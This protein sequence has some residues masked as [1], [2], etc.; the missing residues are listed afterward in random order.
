MM[1]NR[2]RFLI[3]TGGAVLG[4]PL[5][6][7]P[8][9]VRADD[10]V[11][12]L[13]TVFFGNGLPP[14]YAADLE[15]PLSP[16]APWR[17]QLSVVRGLDGGFA[18]EDNRLDPHLQGSGGF[19]V[20]HAPWGPNQAGGISIDRAAYVAQHPSTPLPTLEMGMYNRGAERLRAVKTWASPRRPYPPIQNPA[21]LF[22]R[23]FGGADPSRSVLDAVVGEYRRVSSDAAGYSIASRALIA[24][25]LD[26][27][28]ELERKIVARETRLAENACLV[29]PMP[30]DISPSVGCLSEEECGAWGIPVG[31]ATSNWDQVWSLNCELYALALSCDMVRFGSIVCTSG[32]DRYSIPGL[33]HTPH[34]YAHEWRA[35]QDNEFAICVEWTMSK[36]A[37][38]LGHLG[39]VLDR[40][41]VLIGT[42]L[43]DP[44]PHSHKDMTYILAGAP[45]HLQ[46]GVD[47]D[48]EGKTVVDLLSTVSTL[49]NTG[50][51]FGDPRHFSGHLPITR[52]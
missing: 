30:P 3:G 41:L 38:L 51:V 27:V 10:P 42:E 34:G 29:P 5:L 28:R 31:P 35:H 47:Y 36:I 33:T 32:G 52:R 2:R 49:T 20:G 50:D 8:S 45:S 44:A 18:Q 6:L 13:I 12:R 9:P 24:E 37:E 4:L 23:I 16:L 40:T 15:G 7:E 25:H 26:T 39:P 14:P 21:R 22:R 17:S 46:L 19:G 43:G 48:F 1:L 11:Q